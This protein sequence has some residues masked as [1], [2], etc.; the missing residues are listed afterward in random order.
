VT[1]KGRK[2][3]PPTVAPDAIGMLRGRAGEL[4]LSDWGPSVSIPEKRP[5]GRG[6]RIPSEKQYR[7]KTPRLARI[8]ATH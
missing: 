7:P 4:N 6:L 3:R 8:A 1:I 5:V 2:R